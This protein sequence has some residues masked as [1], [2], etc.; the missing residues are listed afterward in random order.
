MATETHSPHMH[1][2]EGRD[3]PD[4]E[5]FDYGRVA[6]TSKPEDEFCRVFGYNTRQPDGGFEGPIPVAFD[7]T[8]R[9]DLPELKQAFAGISAPL[10]YIN[11]ALAS[12]GS[13]GPDSVFSFD[14]CVTYW[15]QPGWTALPEDIDG[16][17]VSTGINKDWY[18]SDGCP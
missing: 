5:Y 3:E 11:L 2:D 15:Y 4:C 8:A 9:A 14:R 7:E 13:V 6:F 16:E 12:D 10:D 17:T 18:E 1:D